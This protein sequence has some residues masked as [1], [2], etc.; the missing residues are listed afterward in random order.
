[1]FYN[2]EGLVTEID[3]NLIVLDCNGIGFAVNASTH[4]ISSVKIKQRAKLYI[5]EAIGEDH[6]DLYGF[7][8]KDEKRCFTMLLSVSGIGPKAALSI[9]SYNTPDGLALAIA[10][11]N[12]KPLTSCPGIG[13]KTAQRILLEL[14]DKLQLADYGQ[15]NGNGFS[16]S[17]EPIKTGGDNYNNAVAALTVLGYNNNDIA[18]ALKQENTVGMTTEEIIKLAL[19]KMSS[20]GLNK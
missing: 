17:G 16:V 8:S 2:L 19:K 11:G 20:G 9:M 6:F 12:D 7:A 13:K 3:Q 1:M 18:S 10:N 15:T 4:T 5:Y 14:K